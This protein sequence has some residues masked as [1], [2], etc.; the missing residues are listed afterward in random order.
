MLQESTH[1]SKFHQEATCRTLTPTSRTTQAALPLRRI[2][3]S[4]KAN[5]NAA[6]EIV[7]KGKTYFEQIDTSVKYSRVKFRNP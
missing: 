3:Q 2:T 7:I 6:A 5:H 1:N 4:P